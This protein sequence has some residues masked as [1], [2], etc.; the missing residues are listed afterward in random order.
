MRILFIGD[1]VGKPGRDILRQQLR[2]IQ[3]KFSIDFTIANGENAAGGAGIN[4]RIFDE[5]SNYGV[6]VITMGNHV[7]DKKEI[8]DFIENEPRILRPANYP[9]GT[10]GKGWNI[11]SFPNQLKI[12]VINLSGRVFLPA[13]DCPFQNIDL[14]LSQIKGQTTHI[15]V[16]FHAEATSE[17]QAMGWYLDGRVSA[18]LGTH[19]HVQTA[20]ARILNRGTAY[21]TDVGMTGPRDSVLG[22]DK[23]LVIKKFTTS[24]PVR[25]EVAGGDIQLNAVIIEINHKGQAG[26]IYPFQSVQEAL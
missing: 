16:D 14:I 25:F 9:K 15:I 11:F 5:I 10:P 23:E 13:L 8:F 18:V 22:V 4:K 24:L 7:W 17:K 19:T 21:I 3:D 2:N 6:D 12:A 20:D 26:S 1:I